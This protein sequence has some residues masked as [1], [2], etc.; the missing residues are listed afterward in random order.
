[1][2]SNTEYGLFANVADLLHTGI[3]GN[4][5]REYLNVS[6]DSGMDLIPLACKWRTQRNERGSNSWPIDD[7]RSPNGEAFR[8]RNLGQVRKL[9]TT[10]RDL[11]L[12]LR[13]A[14]PEQV[15]EYIER[16]APEIHKREFDQGGNL[17]VRLSGTVYQTPCRTFRP[18]GKS[19]FNSV[20]QERFDGQGGTVLLFRV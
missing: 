10:L 16:N 2:T 18:E 19:D 9:E 20:Y 1:M 14:T 8:F 13:L 15:R 12:Q 17:L 4:E 3:S 5:L 11:D 7:G 6:M